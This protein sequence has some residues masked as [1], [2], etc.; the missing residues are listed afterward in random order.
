MFPLVL[1]VGFKYLER[2]QGMRVQVATR[3]GNLLLTWV[4]EEIQFVDCFTML[5][6]FTDDLM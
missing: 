3:L 4:T 2:T 1:L 5:I 6:K